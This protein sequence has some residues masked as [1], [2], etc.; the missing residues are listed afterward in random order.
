MHTRTRLALAALA[1]VTLAGC[2][3]AG[4]GGDSAAD[5]GAAEE[6][7]G[8]AVDA[9]A[10]GSDVGM[11]TT[12]TQQRQ[13]I[14]TAQATVQVDDPSASADD[15][16]LL[17]ESVGGHVEGR[18][19]QRGNDDY[20]GHAWLVLRVP[21]E[22]LSGVIDDLETVGDVR[23][24]SQSEDDVTGTVQDLDARIAAL[25]TSTQRLLEIMAEADDTTDLLAIEKQLSERQADLEALQTQR[26]ALGD[27]V[28]LS[29]LTITLDAEP[30][31]PVV[32][33]GGFVGGLE[34]GWNALVSF[35]GM[36]LVA[37]GAL[38]PWVV[39]L[40]LPALAL[41]VVLRRRRKPAP[42]QAAPPTA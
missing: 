24:V 21:A 33:R 8:I 18:E 28:A 19:E 29:T 5:G 38:L 16:V 30:V 15:V 32:A 40:G 37:L 22:E 13:V 35:V 10:A 41:M 17:V 39:A 14:V 42:A 20:P 31:T 34:S 23:S 26:D 4:G 7:A 36:L 11:D 6:N 2:S 27:Q 9:S 25:E 1:L 3:S 12:G